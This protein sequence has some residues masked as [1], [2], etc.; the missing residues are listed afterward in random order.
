MEDFLST[1]VQV[2]GGRENSLINRKMIYRILG[3]LL[4]LEAMLFLACMGVSLYYGE[5]DYICFVYSALINAGVGGTLIFLGRHAKNIV[6]RRDG[7]CIVAF[8]WML[9]TIFGMLPYLISGTI[10]SVTD[11]FFETMSGFTT[12]GAT[13]LD[14]VESLSH[15]ILF[16]R[17][18][19]QWIGGL[20]IVFF[21]IVVLPIFGVGNQVL[22]KAE[23][24]GVTHDKIHPKIS[25]MA[26]WL[27]TVYLILTVAEAVLLAV[28]GMG[29][30]DA[31]CHAFGTTATGGFSTKQSS[32]AYWNSPFIEY[33]IAVFMILSGMNF[34]LYFMCLRGRYK[35]LFHD[36]EAKW[37]VGSIGC[38]A[39]LITVSLVVQN[40]Y[41]AE[42]AF[43][44]SL[45][46]VAT[47]HTSSGFI[48]DDYI[49]WAPFT[50][51]LLVYCMIVG[52]CTG[53]T[54]GGVKIMRLLIVIRNIKNEFRRM[55]H[56]HA[57][58]PIKVN[59]MAVPQ[60]IISMASTF[61]LLYFG[62]IFMGWLVYMFMG[63]EIVEALGIT[64]SSL[65]NTGVA[66]GAFGPAYSW[67]GL[68]EAG[69]WLSSFLMLIGRLELFG[70]LLIFSPAFWEKR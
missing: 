59:R 20:G 11:A 41:G 47:L 24:T 19:T 57:V 44:K 54:C 12:T 30:F 45:F 10:P 31:V 25:V 69:K 64:I 68:P 3:I 23:A 37:F 60:S 32:V 65:G 21:T 52:G 53:S 38:V 6:T 56:P 27:W 67:N 15:G 17:S 2:S 5:P 36:D 7:Y 50:W 13:I 14:D 35:Q 34:S 66:L 33:V 49:H 22:F 62:C 58:L 4:L 29:W 26:K 40:G 39:L 42:E 9:F 46:Q 16:W 55:M 8:T 51:V 63:L 61:V 70:V 18:F 43:R 28:G 1:R 48:T